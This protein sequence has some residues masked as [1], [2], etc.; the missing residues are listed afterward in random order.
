LISFL[1]ISEKYGRVYKFGFCFSKMEAK[2]KI[3]QTLKNFIEV[4]FNGSKIKNF[5]NIKKFHRGYF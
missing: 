5:P 2:L 3:F 4:I 1:N